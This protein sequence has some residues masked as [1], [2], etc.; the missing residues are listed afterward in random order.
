MKLLALIVGT[1]A[2]LAAR[3]LPDEWNLIV[4]ALL[5]GATCV[6]AEEHGIRK[7]RRGER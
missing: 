6:L 5:L 2:I 7:G 4:P 3:G 1:L